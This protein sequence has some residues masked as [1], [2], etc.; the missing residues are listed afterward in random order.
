MEGGERE[1]GVYRTSEE[2]N[3]TINVMERWLAYRDICGHRIPS[4]R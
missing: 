2:V 3:G 1:S 4:S